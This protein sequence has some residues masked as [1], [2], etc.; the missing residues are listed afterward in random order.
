MMGSGGLVV[1]DEDTAWSTWPSSSWTSSSAKAAASAF[2]AA[3]AR[4][5]CWRSCNAS[6]AAGK[7]EAGIEPWNAS[8]ACCTAGLAEV[9]RDTSLCGLG[10]TA[11]NPV[12]STLRWFRDEYEAHILRAASARRRLH[13][14]AHLHDRRRKVQGLHG[15]RQEMPGRRDRGRAKSP[16][17]IVVD[18]CIGCGTVRRRLP[19]RRRREAINRNCSRRLIPGTRNREMITI[20]VNGRKFPP[21]KG[22]MLL[23]TRCD[24]RPSSVPTLCHIDGPTASGACR[25]CVVEVEGQR[26]LVPSCAFPVADGMKVKHA[27]AARRASPQDDRR[28][29]AGQPSRRLP[30]LQPQRQLPIAGNWPRSTACASGASPA[31]SQSGTSS[32]TPPARRSCAIR[33]S[34]FSA[35]SACGCAR[36]SRAW[37]P[38]TSSAA[39]RNQVGPAFDEGLN[40]SSCINCGQCM[41]VVCPTGALTEQSHIKKCWTRSTIRTSYRRRAARAGRFGHAG[42]RVRPAA[43]TDVIGAM[44]AALRR[45]GFDRV[46]DTSFTAD[47]TI[48]EEAS[49]WWHGSRTAAAAHVDQLLA[50]LDQVRRDQYPA[51]SSTTSRPARARSR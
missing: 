49:S 43:G 10:Q 28:A 37:R 8:R 16:H 12:L 3:K 20:E 41:S 22:E 32:W 21:K 2:P 13:R 6:P 29:A 23:S 39:A 40:V 24:A 51:T 35:A 47:L 34:A 30:V 46:F 44:T 1:M 18:K 31:T 25:M 9:I 7:R 42:R 38:S 50:G 5:A 45:L 4:A 33:P 15:V 17:Y 48:M 36:K 14:T 11:P 26:G 19:L 27:F